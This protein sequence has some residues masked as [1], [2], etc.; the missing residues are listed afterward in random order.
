MTPE[1]IL[2]I[3]RDAGFKTEAMNFEWHMCIGKFA[4]FLLEEER[5]ICANLAETPV[6]SYDVVIACGTEP[7][8]YKIPRYLDWQSIATAIRS[9]S[10]ND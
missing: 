10:K 3:A 9:R 8:P 5:Q 1:K 6:G 4:K 7:A 2:S